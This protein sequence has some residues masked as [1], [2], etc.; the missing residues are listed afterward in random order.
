M[1]QLVR[2]SK[3]KTFLL[4]ADYAFYQKLVN[5]LMP[6]VL[7][8]IPNNLTQAIRNFAKS[9]EGWMASALARA[10]AEIRGAIHQCFIIILNS[11]S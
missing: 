9:L 7:K 10:P 11:D 4:E 6:K 3:V 1:A 5:F 2:L 8:T